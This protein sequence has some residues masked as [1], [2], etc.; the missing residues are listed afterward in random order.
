MT[1][2]SFDS[3]LINLLRSTWNRSTKCRVSS[4]ARCVRPSRSLGPFVACTFLLFPVLF[5]LFSFRS[6]LDR[7]SVLLSVCPTRIFLLYPVCARLFVYFGGGLNLQLPRAFSGLRPQRIFFF[8]FF[9]FEPF[10]FFGVVERKG[11]APPGDV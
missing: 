4:L 8:V 6:R 10:W 1:V 2:R 7:A 3:P 11:C 9:L 5:F